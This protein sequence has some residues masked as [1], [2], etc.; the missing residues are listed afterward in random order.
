MPVNVKSTEKKALDFGTI[1]MVKKQ[2]VCYSE[3]KGGTQVCVHWERD[4]L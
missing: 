3:K 2:K 4:S 1:V